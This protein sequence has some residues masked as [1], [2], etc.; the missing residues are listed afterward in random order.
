MNKAFRILEII[1]L[2]LGF[3]GV[4]MCGYFIIIQDKQG[5][6][7]FIIFT[8]MCGLMYSV[9]RRQRMKFEANQKNK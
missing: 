2:V 7:Y 5:A 1:W 6:I 3:I 8:V 4:L 9:R